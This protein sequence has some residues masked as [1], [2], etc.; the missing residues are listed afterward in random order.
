MHLVTKILISVEK[1]RKL[2]NGGEMRWGR[3]AFIQDLRVL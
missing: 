2:I 3:G 1:N